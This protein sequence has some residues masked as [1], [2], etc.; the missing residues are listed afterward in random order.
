MATL[1]AVE[2]LL[3]MFCFM[4]DMQN[5]NTV[6]KNNFIHYSF[7]FTDSLVHLHM[8]RH[9]PEQLHTATISMDCT[10]THCKTQC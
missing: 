3:E 4:L 7:E 1:E 8:N 10:Q 6:V 2:D 5:Y 9:F